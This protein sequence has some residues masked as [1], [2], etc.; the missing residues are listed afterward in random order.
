MKSTV[1]LLVPSTFALVLAACG[2]GP[3]PIHEPPPP[4]ETTETILVPSGGK[5]TRHLVPVPPAH[6]AAPAAAIAPGLAGPL[7][8][9]R[10]EPYMD[11]LEVDLRRHVHG[12]GLVTARRGNEIDMVIAD[13]LLFTSDGGVAGD[14]VLEPLASILR[15]YVHTTIAVGG[16]TDSAG[17][18]ANSMAVS[19]KHARSIADALVHEGVPAN[20]I[21]A[22]G[23]G[24]AH[25]RIATG[26]HKREPRNRR[27]EIVITALPG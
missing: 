25:L 21:S 2:G 24:Q 13:D 16:Y 27:V 5:F 14:D 22:Q 23:Y 10:I 12:H 19:Q 15:G 26:D 6:G 20:R 18:P 11:A 8:V 7:T 1:R 9:A 17:T 3:R 4:R